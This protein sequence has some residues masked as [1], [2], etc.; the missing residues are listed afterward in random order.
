[1][2]LKVER[3]EKEEGGAQRIKPRV[4]RGAAA[5][6][7]S[8]PSAC[9][10]R[11]CALSGDYSCGLGA[12]RWCACAGKVWRLERLEN[13]VGGV[14]F[15]HQPSRNEGGAPKKDPRVGNGGG[16]RSRGGGR[17]SGGSLGRRRR[18]R[19]RR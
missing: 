19:G 16:V 12:R 15:K 3:E 1:R 10:R 11:D 4:L 5:R 9:S 17:C 2:Q 18:R 14:R 13:V 8:W 6:L 7:K